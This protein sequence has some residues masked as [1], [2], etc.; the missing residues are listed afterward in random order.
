MTSIIKIKQST[1]NA[2]PATLQNGEFS[3]GLN[4]YDKLLS[5]GTI[6][7]V[8]PVNAFILYNTT[9]NFTILSFNSFTVATGNITLTLPK[10]SNFNL[11]QVCIIR[12]IGALF[13]ITINAASGDT[14]NGVA[15]TT[16]NANTAIRLISSSVGTIYSY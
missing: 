8:Q 15:S 14:I 1:T 13:I 10:S 6:S 5:I 3:V 9:T 4:T 16:L 12:N 2:S 7:G 11:G